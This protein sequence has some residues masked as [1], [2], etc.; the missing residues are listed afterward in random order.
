MRDF[1]LVLPTCNRA[2]MFEGL[3]SYLETQNADCRLLV[4]DSSHPE[5]RATN[6]ERA[7][8]SALNV[9]FAEL[10]DLEPF[11]KLRQGIHRVTTPYCAACEDGDLVILD[12]LRRCLDVL[13]RNPMASAVQGHSFTFLLRADGGMELNNIVNLGPTIND[14]SPCGRVDKLFQVYSPLRYGV[15]RTRAAQRTFEA[16]RSMKNTI[17]RELLW[18][19]L[20]AVEGQLVRIVD[21]SYGRNGSHST[22]EDDHH[23]LTWFCNDSDSVFAEYLRYRELLAAAIIQRLDNEQQAEAVHDILDLIHLRYL[24]RRVPES[25][26]RFVAEQEIVGVDFAENWSRHEGQLRT[27][28]AGDI[29]ASNLTGTLEPVEIHGRERSY[30]L[31]PSFYAP[32]DIDSPQMDIIVH[33]IAALDGYRRRSA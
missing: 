32:R 12:G 6:H 25:V 17:S 27:C 14:S 22:G 18:S 20:T 5:V 3:L 31:F 23:L 30:Q 19:A 33:L 11:E 29:K 8:A 16:L 28:D 26:L 4:L 1:T 7:A 21:F 15:F 10:P 24:S 9:E 13:R 2:E